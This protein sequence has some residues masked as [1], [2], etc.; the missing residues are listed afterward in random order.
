MHS[1]LGHLL[2]IIILLLPCRLLHHQ[3]QVHAC[4][5]CMH[6]TYVMIERAVVLGPYVLLLLLRI[7]ESSAP[8]AFD[9]QELSLSLTRT[10]VREDAGHVDVPLHCWQS[11]IADVSTCV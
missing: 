3:L 1:L 7:L 5:H 4:L 2:P 6:C 10:C 11:T 8:T 9:F